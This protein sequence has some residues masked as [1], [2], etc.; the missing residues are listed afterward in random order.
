[1]RFTKITAYE[2][3]CLSKRSVLLTESLTMYVMIRIVLCYFV[4]F[5]SLFDKASP[6]SIEDIREQE[7]QE[8]WHQVNLEQLFKSQKLTM[9][10]NVAKNV[11]IFI[12]DGMGVSTITAARWLKAKEKTVKNL[13]FDKFPH[14]ALIQVHTCCK[15]VVRY[16]K[17]I[18]NNKSCTAT[19]LTSIKL[20]LKLRTRSKE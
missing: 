2:K 9:N 17:L 11:I 7:G 8:Y 20:R 1:M 16:T 10:E 18:S 15:I 19:S 12:G 6:L 3:C 4:I 13:V 14:S 5:S